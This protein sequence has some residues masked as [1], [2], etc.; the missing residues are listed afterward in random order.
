M[1][2]QASIVNENW[3]PVLQH[4]L[5]NNGPIYRS[6]PFCVFLATV[7]D[8]ERLSHAYHVSYMLDDAFSSLDKSLITAPF[9]ISFL[10]VLFVEIARAFRAT[11]ATKRKSKRKLPKTTTLRARRS[12]IILLSRETWQPPKSNWKLTSSGSASYGGASVLEPP[13]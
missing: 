9:F 12:R 10:F 1:H 2:L 3:F 7:Y 5:G 11:R 8:R 13:F 4:F 6:N